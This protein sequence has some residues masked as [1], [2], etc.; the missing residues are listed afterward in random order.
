MRHRAARKGLWQSAEGDV[1]S[2][3]TQGRCAWPRNEAIA[4]YF[5]RTQVGPRAVV[6]AQGAG[7][8]REVDVYSCG[9]QADPHCLATQRLCRCTRP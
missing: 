2:Y 7:C 3:G 9:T 5:V 8:C 6:Q 1:Y 4:N